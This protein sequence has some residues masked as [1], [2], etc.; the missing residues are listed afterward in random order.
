MMKD[1]PREVESR[2]QKRF[3]EREFDV[4]FENIYYYV[5]WTIQFF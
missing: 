1:L 2:A 4:N 3:V 5:N